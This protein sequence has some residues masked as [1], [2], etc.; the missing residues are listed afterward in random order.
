MGLLE[1][2]GAGS[3]NVRAGLE[4]GWGATGAGRLAKAGERFCCGAKLENLWLLLDGC[5]AGEAGLDG[6]AATGD[7][8]LDRDLDE[9]DGLALDEDEGLALD[10]DDGLALDEVDDDGLPTAGKFTNPPPD[11]E[12]CLDGADLGGDDS[13][14]LDGA[15]LLGI[16][17]A[18]MLTRFLDGLIFL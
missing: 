6:T 17:P 3:W 9:D 16:A 10:E 5:E 4:A 13:L 8:A 2:A 11:E 18:G 15:A 7:G 1:G 14:D 12:D